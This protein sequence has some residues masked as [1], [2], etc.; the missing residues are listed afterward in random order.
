MPV[1]PESGVPE[2]EEAMTIDLGTTQFVEVNGKTLPK[3]SAIGFGG[4]YRLDE[5]PEGKLKVVSRS[6]HDSIGSFRQGSG[7]VLF[8]G[9]REQL[10]EWNETENGW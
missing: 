6:T 7:R 3:D 4:G 9:T 2:E 1:L 10:V 5:L 8:E